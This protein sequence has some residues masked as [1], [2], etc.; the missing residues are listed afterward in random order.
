MPLSDL[1]P[2]LP[3][4]LEGLMVTG[5][6]LDSRAVRPGDLFLACAGESYHGVEYLEQAIAQGAVV[7]AL[8]PPVPCTVEQSTIPTIEIAGLR[9]KASE[10]AGRFYHHPSY[11]LQLIGVTGTNGKS[12]VA[13]FIADALS[14]SGHGCGLIGTL[15][16]GIFGDIKETG[17]T[18]PDPVRLQ[19]DLYTMQQQGVTEVVMEVS[20]HALEQGRVDAL[21][22]DHAI[23]TNLTHD[24]L[25]YHGT[26]EHYASAK[27][28][29]FK[30]PHLRTA[31]INSDDAEGERMGRTLAAG[32]EQIRYGLTLMADGQPPELF[33]HTL[34]FSMEGIKMGI[35]SPWGEE[36]ILVPLLGRFNASNTLAALA[37]L[38]VSGVTFSDACQ[39]LQRLS[40]VPGRMERVA[41]Q[42]DQPTV[43]VDFAHTPDALAHALSALLPHCRGHLWCVFGAGGDRDPTKRPLMGAVVERLADRVVITSDNPRSEKPRAI[44]DAILAGM[45]KPG[46]ATLQ[47]DR[48][49]AIA[50]AIN[51]AKSGDLILIAGKGHE[52]VQIMAGVRYPF[53]DVAVATECLQRR[54]M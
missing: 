9:R 53:D 40:Q 41:V 2:D 38:V 48:A 51:H 43:I 45:I 3:P 5:L 54:G 52:Q 47:L 4:E 20:S 35:Q 8:E 11:Q 6:Q 22:F 15:G 1:L 30:N 42:P 13:H 21:A 28:T 23:Y 19:H 16:S 49:R 36:T 18:T 46:N 17:M 32:V 29:L 33:A 50:Y 44:I 26:L 12:S 31:I 14:Q 24:H 27:A 25:D 34:T 37:G 10:I 39:R 7:A